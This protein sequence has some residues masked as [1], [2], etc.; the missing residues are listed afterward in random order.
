M[1]VKFNRGGFIRLNFSREIGD[2]PYPNAAESGAILNRKS[3]III[4]G[5]KC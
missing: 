2:S 5:K 4:H 1:F 3:I